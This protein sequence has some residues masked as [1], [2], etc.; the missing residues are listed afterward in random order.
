MQENYKETI[1]AIVE[2]EI[3]FESD[4]IEDSYQWYDKFFIDMGL[5]KCNSI[6]KYLTIKEVINY[7]IFITI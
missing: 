3:L 1:E 7:E 5:E 4:P 6:K 2:E